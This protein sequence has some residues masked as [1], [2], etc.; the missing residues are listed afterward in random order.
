MSRHL[1]ESGWARVWAV[2]RDGHVVAHASVYDL[3]QGDVVFGH[4]GIQRPYRGQGIARELQAHRFAFLDD[5]GLTL[6][7]AVAAGNQVSLTGCLSY[8]FAV[9]SMNEAGGTVVYRA[10]LAK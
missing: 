5:H 10:P 8:G 1:C 7:G 4:L 2:E 9:A 3:G 6:S